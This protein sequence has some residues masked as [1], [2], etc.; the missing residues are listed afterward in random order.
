M[1]ET[2]MKW[3]TAFSGATRIYVGTDGGRDLVSLFLLSSGRTGSRRGRTKQSGALAFLTCIVNEPRK[4]IHSLAKRGKE[5][6]I[7]RRGS[8]S[9]LSIAIFY[10]HRPTIC[11][12]EALVLFLPV[13]KHQPLEKRKRKRSGRDRLTRSIEIRVLPSRSIPTLIPYLYFYLSKMPLV[14]YVPPSPI[15]IT[16]ISP[17][18]RHRRIRFEI[19]TR[20]NAAA[21]CKSIIVTNDNPPQTSTF[22]RILLASESGDSDGEG[23]KDARNGRNTRGHRPAEG[24]SP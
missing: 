11:L 2:R 22:A 8:L 3:R 6:G 9:R 12:P 19:P 4:S 23:G 14:V 10:S 5:E 20:E 1:D 18:P 16:Y 13:Y 7:G 17:F 21:N 15:S 24:G